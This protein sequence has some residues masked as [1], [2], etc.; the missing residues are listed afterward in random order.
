MFTDLQIGLAL[1]VSS[2]VAVGMIFA[3]LIRGDV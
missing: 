3:Y 2:G 1:G